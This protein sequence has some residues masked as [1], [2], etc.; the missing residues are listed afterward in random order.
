MLMVQCVHRDVSFP[1]PGDLIE[2]FGAK[3][4]T[5]TY[6]THVFVDLGILWSILGTAMCASICS[7]F[8]IY[9]VQYKDF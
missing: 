3:K 9:F 6:R 5:R 7:V 2:F 8:Q 1:I 4:K